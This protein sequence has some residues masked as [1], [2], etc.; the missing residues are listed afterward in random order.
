M[1]IQI[2][3]LSR[4]VKFI[5]TENAEVLKK[6]KEDEFEKIKGT[7]PAIDGFRKGTIPRNVAEKKFGIE[8]LYNPIFDKIYADVC[9]LHNIV[10]SKD[11]RIFGNFDD[12]SP[13][14]IE[15]IA[16]MEP[17][18][19][20]VSY[21]DI[22]IEYD[23]D[24]TISE[25]AVQDVLNTALKQNEKFES[26][27]KDCLENLDNVEIDFEGTLDGETV[28]FQNGSAKKYRCQI[29][30][31]KKTFIDTFEEQ[32]LG[33]KKGEERILNVCFPKNYGDKTKAGKKAKFK[34]FLHTV[35]KSVLP[36]L[37]DDFAK[38]MKFDTLDLYKKSI[39]TNLLRDREITVEDNFK[40]SMIRELI[41]KSEFEPIPDTMIENETER[42]W[43]RYL[44]RM[45]KT[46]AEILKEY[47]DIKD[48]FKN[49]HFGA[50]ETLIKTTLIL[51]AVAEKE[52]IIATKEEVETYVLNISM[53]LKYDENKKTKILKE[54]E[55]PEIY[56]LHQRSVINEK[57]VTFLIS[58]LKK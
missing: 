54:L 40:K 35:L 46:E 48:H 47:P 1:E 4:P 45:G 12:K 32:M 57:V 51:K 52:K 10:S 6:M 44:G 25:E 26:I 58:T 38:T 50:S 33:M 28:P 16:E 53:G 19:N 37:N 5:V 7:L 17:T 36:E 41:E 11:F 42:D 29:N 8:K 43:R 2:Q 13:L 20:V 9:S 3:K 30:L 31:E 39:K 34:V 15:F 22:K 14:K 21:N 49:E 55:K 23:N 27:E 56:R 24:L 18:V